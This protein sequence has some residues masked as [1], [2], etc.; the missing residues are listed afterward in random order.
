MTIATDTARLDPIT[1]E[2][3]R[4]GF[5]AMCTEASTL[6]ERVSFSPTLTEGHDCSVSILT[7]ARAAQ[8]S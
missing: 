5:R 2:V 4:N 3:L 1:F 6:I 7:P 8:R